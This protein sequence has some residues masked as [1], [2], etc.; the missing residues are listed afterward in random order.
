MRVVIAPDKFKG[1]LSAPEAAR[2]DGAAWPRLRPRRRSTWC[3]WPTAARGRSRPWSRR[4]AARS[5]RPT[6]T[7][8]LGEPVVAPVR[9]AR[10]RPD[11]RDRDGGGLGAGARAAPTGATR[12]RT[13]T[14]GTGELLL[15]AIAAGARRVIVGIGGSA[16]NDGGAG[17]GQALGFRLLDAEGREL[18]PG[19]G[20]LGRLDRIDASGRDPSSTASRSPSPATST[21]RSAARAAPRPSTARRRGRRRRWSQVLDRNL[22]HFAAIVERD[23]GVA[24][25]DLPGAGAAGGLGGGL[26]A[27]AGGR[28]EPGIDAGHRGRRPGRAP[29]GRRPLPDRRR[30]DRR[31]ERL[32]QD[33]R[34]RRPARPLARLPDAR[35]GRHDRPG[36]RGRPRP[37]ASTPIFSICP[38]PI[39][40]DEAI[41]DAAE[42]LEQAAE[43]AVRRSWRARTVAALESSHR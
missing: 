22:A 4:P 25:R 20:A 21:T 29:R 6:V 39:D 16:T 42:L 7:G 24:I 13:T 17:L 9:P 3:R 23:L 41:A 38:G 18:E 27:F 14:R 31:L 8:P 26:V 40:L 5:A 35:P 30:G 15:A 37:R 2:G 33:G 36:R 32:R 19:G 11:G 28:L 1:S 34:R 43:Q 10:R 12:C